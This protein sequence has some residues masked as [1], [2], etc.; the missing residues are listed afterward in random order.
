MV[1]RIEEL[2]AGL[3]AED[4]EGQEDVLALETAAVPASPCGNGE[5]AGAGEAAA[6]RLGSEAGDA[7]QVLQKDGMLWTV[8]TA[9]EMDAA[10]GLAPERRM[11]RR[12]EDPLTARDGGTAALAETLRTVRDG[13]TA[14][15]EAAGLPVSAAARAGVEWAVRTRTVGPEL[16]GARGAAPD[17]AGLEG[18]YQ[19]TVRAVWPA[20]PALPQET[21]GRSARAREPG[22][23]AAL[24][25]DGLDRAV[26]RDSRRY[27]GEMMI[28]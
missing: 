6:G 28:Y 12:P 19:Q 14:A 27:D 18:L 17:R 1:D 10:Q 7:A 21:A 13:G 11:E 24:A 4:D 25:V 23:A 16:E 8:R 20:A 9:A 15:F 26:R 2:L 22:D 3:A 5:E